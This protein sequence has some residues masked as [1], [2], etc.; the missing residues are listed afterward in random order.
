MRL[1]LRTDVGILVVHGRICCQVYSYT[2]VNIDARISRQKS[3]AGLWY[4]SINAMR[5]QWDDVLRTKIRWRHNSAICRLVD[6]FVTEDPDVP[7]LAPVLFNRL[8]FP[9][10]TWFCE[11]RKR[12]RNSNRVVF[13]MSTNAPVRRRRLPINGISA[14][15]KTNRCPPVGKRE[16]YWVWSRNR[17]VIGMQEVVLGK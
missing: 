14:V 6:G 7:L 13:L 15:R 9:S 1:Y 8:S 5:T 17:G 12:Y 11:G 4:Y 2:P 10:Y 16:N 3:N